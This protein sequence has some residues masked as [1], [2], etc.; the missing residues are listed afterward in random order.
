MPSVVPV[1]PA[2]EPFT[3]NTPLA[4]VALPVSPTWPTSWSS[5][6]VGSGCE[7]TSNIIGLLSF[8]LGATE[9]TIGPEVAPVGMVMLI[10]AEFQLLIVTGVPFKT[11]TLPFCD[12]PNPEPKIVTWLPIDPVVADKLEITGVE[13]PDP[14]AL[15][16]TLSKAVVARLELDPL[17]TASPT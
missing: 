6:G 11:T 14:D 12:P 3:V 5:Q 1:I 2:P 15:T 4:Y 16:D 17:L 10:D 7:V 9:T 8:M 13:N